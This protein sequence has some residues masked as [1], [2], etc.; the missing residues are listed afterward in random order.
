[1]NAWQLRNSQGS[2]V[3]S[4][5]AIAGTK[6][7]TNA[8]NQQAWLSSKRLAPVNPHHTYEV[9]GSFR[10][11]TTTGS[12]GGIYLA[13]LLYDGAKAELTGDGTWWFYPVA[14]ASLA[15]TAWH[16]YSARFG[17]GT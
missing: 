6:V 12:A 17:A 5:S 8:V 10:R 7:F 11:P 2:I 16:T 14:G 3:T 13:V 15:D 1:M 9:T 4:T